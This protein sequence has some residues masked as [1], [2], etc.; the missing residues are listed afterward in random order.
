MKK[1]TIIG[2]ALALMATHAAAQN[3]KVKND[4][5]DCGSVIYEQPVTVKFELQNCS[6]APLQIKTVRTSCGCTQVEY[7]KQSIAS[8]DAFMVMAT[9]DARQLGHFMKDIGIYTDG[10][11]Q[12]LY[13]S[14]R[15]VVVEEVMDYAGNYPCSIGQVKADKN[16]IEFDDVNRGEMPSAKIHI[17]NASSDAI[18]PVVMHLPAYLKATVSPT[19][20]APNR[21]GVVTLM[22]DS[23]QLRDYGLSQTS[24]FLGMFPGDKVSPEKEIE[25]SAV[26]LPAFTQMTESQLAQAP[27]LQLSQQELTFDFKAKSK[28]KTVIMLQNVGSSPLDISAI[29]MFT[30][31]LKVNLNKTHLL[32]NEQTKLKITVDGNELRRARSKPRVLMITNDPANPKVVITINAE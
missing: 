10:S 30:G 8:G 1:Q 3:I 19:T 16:A 12:P 25:V 17:M 26:L 29:Q 15:G 6:V 28:Q 24:V 18:S 27:R 31:G 23:R 4:V 20:I 13:L 7:P 22:L 5:I 11:D 9:Y 21:Q 14:I 2:I 32:P